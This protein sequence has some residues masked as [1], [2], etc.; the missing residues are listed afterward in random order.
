MAAEEPVEGLLIPLPEILPVASRY[1]SSVQD[2]FLDLSLL[3]GQVVVVI[4]V[5]VVL[6]WLQTLGVES[7]DH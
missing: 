6:G 5:V 7:F 2:A 3:W 4:A 1:L